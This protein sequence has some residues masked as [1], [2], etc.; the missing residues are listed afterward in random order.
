MK[1]NDILRTAAELIEQRAAQRDLEQERS[2][3]RTVDVFNA[4]MG[5]TRP[6]ERMTEQEGWMF[7]ICLKLV[8]ATAGKPM[9]DDWMDAAAYCA[10]GGESVHG[11]L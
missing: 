9:P 4:L 3:A 2:M 11:Q 8:R 7:M 6:N 10:L 5:L 1:A